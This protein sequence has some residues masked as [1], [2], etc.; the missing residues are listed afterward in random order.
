MSIVKLR[1]NIRC[2]NCSFQSFF[3]LLVRLIRLRERTGA[4]RAT[5]RVE[6]L[7]NIW[8]SEPGG[9]DDDDDNDG[10]VIIIMQIRS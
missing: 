10:D 5:E 7:M 2:L 4:E 8:G 9:D 6:I 1:W 3:A